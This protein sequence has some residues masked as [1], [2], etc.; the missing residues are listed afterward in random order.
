MNKKK[1][2]DKKIIVNSYQKF[3]T[4]DNRSLK[5]LGYILVLID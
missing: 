1:V 5:L 3:M 4:I 2:M